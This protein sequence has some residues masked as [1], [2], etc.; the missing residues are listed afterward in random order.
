MNELLSYL[1]L[2]KCSR[3]LFVKGRRDGEFTAALIIIREKEMSSGCIIDAEGVGEEDTSS[4]K[5][6]VSSVTWIV[7]MCIRVGG[8]RLIEK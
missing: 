4:R 1:A 7:Q 8:N 6:S 2:L 5:T 3:C